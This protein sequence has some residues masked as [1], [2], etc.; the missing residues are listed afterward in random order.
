[1]MRCG[2]RECKVVNSKRHLCRASMLECSVQQK[3]CETFAQYDAMKS[4][5]E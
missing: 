4:S 1:M 2:G 5:S 3:L